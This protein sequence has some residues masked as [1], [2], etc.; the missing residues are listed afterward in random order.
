MTETQTLVA[1][2]QDLAVPSG[3]AHSVAHPALPENLQRFLLTGKVVVVT[4]FVYS[5]LK[6]HIL[7]TDCV[8]IVV[9]VDLVTVC[10]RPFAKL[11]ARLLP[12]WMFCR[13]TAIPRL[14][15]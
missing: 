3:T 15:S 5:Y 13:N 4:G 9:L 6:Y 10:P 14:S 12:S 8:I 11:A 7:F 2:A 1:S